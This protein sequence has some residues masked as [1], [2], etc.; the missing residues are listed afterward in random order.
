MK[1]EGERNQPK[2]PYLD[3]GKDTGHFVRGLI[4]NPPG[5]H[6]LGVNMELTQEEFMKIW[7]ETLGV[8]GS[9]EE[10]RMEELTGAMPPPMDEELFDSFSFVREFGWTG[11]DESVVMPHEVSGSV[12]EWANA[13]KT[14]LLTIIVARSRTST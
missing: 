1:T 14:H 6:M 12:T 13:L 10:G 9:V 4:R 11:G 5:K 8:T 3:A 7:T 2:L